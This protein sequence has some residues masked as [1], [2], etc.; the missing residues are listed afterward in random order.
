VVRGESCD[1]V[2]SLRLAFLDPVLPRELYRSLH[3]LG[4]WVISGWI[5]PGLISIHRSTNL[6]LT[7]VHKR[8]RNKCALAPV[9][10]P[11]G[12]ACSL[13]APQTLVVRITQRHSLVIHDPSDLLDAIAEAGDSC[14][15]RRA[16]QHPP[17]VGEGKV[18][19]LG[20]DGEWLRGGMV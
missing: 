14:A 15:A 12:Q 3:R 7:R 1:K 6:A 13:Q 8:P 11:L 2:S 5:P 17:A 16:V 20:R 9:N 10:K 19:P 18:E 4:S